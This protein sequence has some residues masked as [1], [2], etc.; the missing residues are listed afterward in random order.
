ML[1]SCGRVEDNHCC[2]VT[3]KVVTWYGH[4]VK[5]RRPAMYCSFNGA[6]IF[7]DHF[8]SGIYVCSKCGYE[9]FSSNTKYKHSSPW[10]AFTNTIHKD[11]VSKK[12]ERPGALKICCGNSLKFIPKETD[13]K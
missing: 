8:E 6:E 13:G 4:A 11:S 3:P 1:P 5:T 7:K 12:E 9:L 2:T 10:P